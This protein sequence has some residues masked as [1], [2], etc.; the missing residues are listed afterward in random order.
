MKQIY[1]KSDTVISRDINIERYLRD[2]RQFQPLLR[3]E[4]KDLLE[5]AQKGDKAAE[6]KLVQANLKFVVNCAKEY[7]TPGVEI[8]D[9]IM[10]GNIGLID[11]VKKYDYKN[12]DVKF[13]SYAVWWIK[14]AI[15]EYLRTYN[16][17]I[18]LPYNQQNEVKRFHKEKQKLEQQ[19]EANLNIE[20]VCDLMQDDSLLNLQ[21]ALV[22]SSSPAFLSDPLNDEDSS[23]VEDLLTNEQED[24]TAIFDLSHRSKMIQDSLKTLSLLQQQILVLSFGLE[25]DIPRTNED[26]AQLL[27][28]TAERIR[29]VRSQALQQLKKNKQLKETL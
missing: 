25:D 13:I 2:I 14:N 21:Q 29:Q 6:H 19:Y 1:S 27:G 16:K 23:T 9:L 20:Q 10:V 12:S 5:K 26:I 28:L 18:R 3:S 11:A 15:I 17:P 4:E 22:V 8:V 24:V 7:Q